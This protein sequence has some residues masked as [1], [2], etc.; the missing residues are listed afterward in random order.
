[1]DQ[2]IKFFEVN[3][4]S[5]YNIVVNIGKMINDKIMRTNISEDKF[6]AIK[7][8]IIPDVFFHQEITTNNYFYQNLEL[9]V[10]PNMTYTV[11]HDTILFI[12]L[13][14]NNI[15]CRVK[16]K[17]DKKID[18]IYF[19]SLDRYNNFFQQHVAI[20]KFPDEL[21]TFNQMMINFYTK[22]S[23]ETFHEITISSHFDCDHI[24]DF[25]ANLKYIL[26]KINYLL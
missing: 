8:K 7:N 11:L 4:L 15:E 9:I 19:P 17:N 5:E 6:N 23:N 26:Q 3:K 18:N 12:D 1:M 24:D 16:V 21:Q 22:K 20:Y 13:K 25:I 10:T 14:I 2:L